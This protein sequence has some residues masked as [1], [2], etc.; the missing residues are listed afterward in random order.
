MRQLLSLFFSYNLMEKIIMKLTLK[1]FLFFISFINL[2]SQTLQP[3]DI[4]II[5][6]N[7][8]TPDDFAFVNLVDLQTGTEIRFTDSGIKSDGTF[9]STEGAVKY[10]APG[11]IT[12]GTIISFVGN[13][14]NF[15]VDSDP[16]VGTNGLAL[17][18]AGDQLIAFQGASSSPSFIYAVSTYRDIWVDATNSNTSALPAG[19]TN[20][21]TA[22]ALG[23]AATD[24]DNAVFNMS[25]TSGTK[26]ELLTA[27]GN[28]ANWT[29]SNSL[30]SMPT[31]SFTV[32]SSS[33]NPPETPVAI[34]ASSVSS[35]SFQANWNS[36]FAASSYFVDVAS[37]TFFT[38]YISGYENLNVGNVTS[39]NVTNL[40]ESTKYFYRVR[41]SN[42]YGISDNSNV[43]SVTTLVAGKTF[44]QFETTAGS[45][46]ESAGTYSFNVSI[47]NPSLTD[48][49]A[50]DIALTGGT[51]TAADIN[52]FTSQHIVFPAGSSSPKLVSLTITNDGITEGEETLVFSIQNITGG[53]QAQTGSN[54]TFTLSITEGT[55][56]YSGIS[57][58]LSGNELRLA[59]NNLI[60]GH[61]QYSYDALWGALKNTDEDPN[62]KGNVILIYSGKSISENPNGGGVDDWNREH[63]WAQSRGGFDTNPGP[64]TDIHHV[65]PE[66]ATV[67]SSR[68]NLDFDWGGIPHPE[69]TGCKYDE[70]SWEPRDAVKGDVARMLFYMDVRYEGENGEPDLQLVDVVGST[71]PGTIGKLSTLLA[72]HIQDPPDEFEKHR[73]DV[74]YSYQK[75]R[76]P[77]ID[78]PEYVVKIWS[79]ASKP[80][81]TNIQRDVL[82]PELNQNFSVSADIV[83]DGTISS[84]FVKYKVDNGN[85]ESVPM[86]KVS[87]NSFSAQIPSSSYSDGSLIQYRIFAYDNEN[88][89]TATAYQSVLAGTTKMNKLHQVDANGNPIY[90]GVFVKVRGVATVSNNVFSGTHLE[91]NLQ[92]STGGMLVYKAN[93][94]SFSFTEGNDYSITGKLTNFNG[95]VELVPANLTD[96]IDHGKGVEIFPNQKTISQLLSDA[97]N[98]ESTLISIKNASKISGTWAAGQNITITDNGG[99]SLLTLHIDSS[100]DLG[101]N[102]EPTYPKDIVGIFSQYDQVSP[103]TSGYQIKPR[104]YSDIKNVSAVEDENIPSKFSLKQ[105]YP[106]PFNPSTTIQFSIPSVIVRQAHYD[107]TDVTLRQAQS[108]ILVTLKVYDILGK[109]VATLVNENKPAGNYEI[110]FD[111]SN[112][113]SGIY[114]YKL[115]SGSFAETKKLLLLK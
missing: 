84:A 91:V 64:G 49:T 110:K 30:I 37:D 69:A 13:S 89:E 41:A 97:E 77:F 81:I 88:N 42:S 5:G 7:A 107:N 29:K 46:N 36:S 112:L 109:E 114:F 55:D 21:L 87:A 50:C 102:P 15:T 83:D 12:A 23:E 2:F 60:K 54:S 106:N 101:S 33:G 45:V 18:T 24:N 43:I 108:D 75:N 40:T 74:I 28:T 92:D 35:T 10:T 25:L 66:D 93:S 62:N 57:S 94:A 3:G 48:S 67:N 63:V 96:I 111:G 38:S 16:G 14:T 9:N 6:I 53:N 19:L 8:D 76:N 95:S 39:A 73:N 99:S 11:F 61:T 78:H 79:L 56:Y 115:Q 34:A 70:D 31:G 58:T 72:W 82:V 32:T 27:I 103:F 51:G 52:N 20:G 1:L 68:N 104:K 85:E 47:I 65:R 86:N 98:L 59:L 71:T 80:I 105:N 44:V 26:T 22:V 90:S 4:A 100:T 17:A 113:S